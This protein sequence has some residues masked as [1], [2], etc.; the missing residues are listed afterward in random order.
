[1][2]HIA[3]KNSTLI[4]LLAVFI[5]SGCGKTSDTP[6]T[7]YIGWAVGTADKAYGTIL[8]TDNDGLT[9]TRQG[10]P[11]QTANVPIYDVSAMSDKEVWAVGGSI[12]GYGLIYHSTS[13]GG[14]WVR[15]GEPGV[16]P[17]AAIRSVFAVDYHTAWFAGDNKTVL[18]S[19][20]DGNTFTKYPLDSIPVVNFTSMAVSGF[21]MIWIV[22]NPLPGDSVDSTAVV[23]HS[24]DAGVTWKRQGNQNTFPS[25]LYD[26]STGNDSVVYIAGYEGVYKTTDGGLTWQK[27]LSKTNLAF[28]GICALDVNNVWTVGDNNSI[29]HTLNGGVTWLKVS[30]PDVTANNYYGVTAYDSF[31]IWITGVSKDTTGGMMLYT[32]NSG[33]TWFIQEYP[34]SAGLLRSCFAFGRR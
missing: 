33:D 6:V 15:Q 9:W 10:S 25:A 26:V 12:D 16:V 19:S 21:T 2:R 1:M 18:F 13:G 8:Y 31:R 3:F 34:G 29:Y 7:K 30:T 27:V 14:L 24:A 22:G 20:D 17:D 32:R 5:I 28:R 11:T 23:V 4:C